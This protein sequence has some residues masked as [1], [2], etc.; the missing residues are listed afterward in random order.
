MDKNGALK[1]LQKSAHNF[2]KNEL[3]NIKPSDSE[4]ITARYFIN[5]YLKDIENN[6]TDK[7][8]F[9]WQYNV[10]SL[11]NYLIEIYCRA[12]MIPIVKQKYQSMEIVKKDK[13]FVEF[14]ES[15][16]NV[17]VAEEKYAKIKRLALY[18]IEKLGGNLP[19]EW[20]IISPAK[21]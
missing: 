13:R 11:L 1:K 17:S 2:L 8:I 5:D 18:C 10:C 20:E 4:L 12:N 9:S 19:A 21:K 3:K 14:F 7:D 16:G 15:I 6:L